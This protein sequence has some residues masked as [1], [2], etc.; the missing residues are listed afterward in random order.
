MEKTA[1][2]FATMKERFSLVDLVLMAP[3]VFVIVS[4]FIR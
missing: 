2:I 3:A 1:Q 4:G